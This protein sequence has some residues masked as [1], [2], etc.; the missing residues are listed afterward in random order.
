MHKIKK[1]SDNFASFNCPYRI[2]NS[3]KYLLDE[4]FSKIVYPNIRNTY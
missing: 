2:N 3:R 1:L 4:E